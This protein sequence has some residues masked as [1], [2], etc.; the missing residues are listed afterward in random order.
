MIISASHIEA[1]YARPGRK[2]KQ[3]LQ[4]FSLSIESG[5][6]NA[7]VGENGAG[8]S[9]FLK[10]CLGFLRPA[11]GTL[12]VLGAVPGT[13]TFR[14]TLL[15][16]GYVP[17]E[18]G[19]GGIPLTVREAAA[20]SRCGMRGLFKKLD[21]TDRRAVD[22]AL[23]SVGLLP[24]SEQLAGELS[25][26]QAQRLAIARALAMEGEL[27]LM[28][29]PTANLDAHCKGEIEQIIK[30]TKRQGMTTVIVSHDREI[31]AYCDRVYHF[32]DGKAVEV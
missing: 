11:S 28:D 25:G 26:G 21:D 5:G 22:R 27:L 12:K 31:S 19:G 23:D 8:K 24:L 20:L 10:L 4:D 7:I 6:I 18:S 13:R 30:E 17:Q 3:V 29:E 15:R 14:K 16:I 9:T 2:P 1:G 32:I